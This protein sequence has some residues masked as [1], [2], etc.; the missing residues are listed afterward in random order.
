M[1]VLALLK[2]FVWMFLC[3]YFL[4]FMP[5]LG[6]KVFSILIIYNGIEN[7]HKANIFQLKKNTK[8]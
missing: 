6:S 1:I 5:R 2:Q 7:T 4:I 3:L 8:W